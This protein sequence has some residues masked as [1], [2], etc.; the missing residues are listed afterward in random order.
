MAETL[1]NKGTEA[2][3]IVED[4]TVGN[5]RVLDLRLARYDVEG[6]LAHIKM[7]QSIGLLTDEELETVADA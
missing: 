2:T 6:S 4:F 5:D 3:Q 7:L 1:W